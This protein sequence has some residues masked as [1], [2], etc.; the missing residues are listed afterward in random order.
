MQ[1]FYD[2]KPSTLEAVGNG[3]YIYR[4]NI[5]EIVP[6]ITDEDINEEHASQWKCQEVTV[7]GP[8]SSNKITE[9]VI[10]E[11]WDPNY[12]QK[13]INEYN[14][15]RLGL[16]SKAEAAEMTEAYKAFL[17]ERAALKAQ[18]DADYE[19]AGLN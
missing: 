4:W 17:N 13:L 6:V 10:S 5:E 7:W 9:A 16:Y 15:A 19:A 1:A 2:H 3:S 8:V 18:I 11:L 14:A 12:E